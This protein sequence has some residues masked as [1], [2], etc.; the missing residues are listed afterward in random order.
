MKILDKIFFR[1]WS[2]K[3]WLKEYLG[4][5]RLYN[6]SVCHGAELVRQEEMI[7]NLEIEISLLKRKVESL[8]RFYQDVVHIGV[9]VHFRSPH[10][11]LVYTRLGGGQI[12]EI[13]ADFADLREL[14]QFCQCLKES[15]RTKQSICDLPHGFP[16]DILRF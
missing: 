14:N 5:K 16:R 2:I 3:G 8:E 10:M 4:I 6:S 1:K 11:I 9:D 12:R 7:R 13:D 15:F